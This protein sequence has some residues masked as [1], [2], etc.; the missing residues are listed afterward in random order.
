MLKH[1]VEY[2]KSY[3]SCERTDLFPV[4]F[5][6]AHS[7]PRVIA[8]SGVFVAYSLN[9]QPEGELTE[10]T[11]TRYNYIKNGGICLV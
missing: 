5:V 4:S 2:N 6:V 7:N 8:Q 10:K 11:E 1:T 9:A 3:K